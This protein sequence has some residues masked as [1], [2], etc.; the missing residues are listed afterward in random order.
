MV[1]II[2]NII[3]SDISL[4]TC[5]CSKLGQGWIMRRDTPLNPEW[6]L[7]SL[8]K[9]T[10]VVSPP[11]FVLHLKMAC[12]IQMLAPSCEERVKNEQTF[13]LERD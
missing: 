9:Y 10:S 6:T 4:V 5:D 11:Y 13:P 3:L 7:L 8:K 1:N 12:P 2:I